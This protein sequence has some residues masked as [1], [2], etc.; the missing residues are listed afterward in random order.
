MPSSAG[1]VVLM[2]CR[3]TSALTPFTVVTTCISTE[4]LPARPAQSIRK[5]FENLVSESQH[6]PHLYMLTAHAQADSPCTMVELTYQ[7]RMDMS[8][9]DVETQT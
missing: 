4:L 5:R 7:Q 9:L 1:V 8:N 3:F 6:N 2:Q